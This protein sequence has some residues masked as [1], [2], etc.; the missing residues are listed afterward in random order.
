MWS[1]IEINLQMQKW[2]V[3]AI[4]FLL[5]RLP[6]KFDTRFNDFG[7]REN[8]YI[9]M[10]TLFC[11]SSLFKPHITSIEILSKTQYSR[12]LILFIE[13]MFDVTIS[14]KFICPHTH[15]RRKSHTER[16]RGWKR[17]FRII[18]KIHVITKYI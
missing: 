11:S 1:K 17:T 18:Y 8:H 6:V 2:E 15:T 3:C 12:L 7:K 5:F 9:G 16:T 14:M 4:F 10:S 13:I